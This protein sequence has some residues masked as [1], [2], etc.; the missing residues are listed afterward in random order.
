MLRFR[1]SI[2]FI[3]T[4]LFL[5]NGLGFLSATPEVR[6]KDIGYIEGIRENQLVGIGLI[7]GLAGK[8]DSSSSEILKRSISNILNN[9][10]FKI[11]PSE[12]KSKNSAV[13]MLTAE[14]PAF[15]HPGD[16]IDVEVS[17][18]ADARS[19]EGGILLQTPLKA[20]NGKI[21]GVAQGKL[22]VDK[23]QKTVGRIHNGAIIEEK[24]ETQ[25]FNNGL[26]S[27]VLRNPD[28]ITAHAVA[29]AI[30]K[31]YPDLKVESRDASYIEVTVPESQRNNLVPFIAS[32]ESVSVKPDSSGKVVIDSDSGVIIMG[33]NVRIGKVAVSYK[34]AKITVGY[35]R[36][37]ENDKSFVM[38][39]TTTVN[40]FV[41]TLKTIGLKTDAVIAI[42]KAI[43]RAGALY[44][45]LIV[46]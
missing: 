28:F 20:A 2:W 21:Y 38:K 3:M 46:M 40:D 45:E 32:L 42:L 7:T 14:I 13:V 23:T 12:I 15:V 17:S 39:E 30:R 44:G 16:R 27:I 5:I 9:F 26:V 1:K 4:G 35:T 41:D 18:I 43:D 37:N 25:F 6:I 29:E 10:G 8:G 11:T 31:K 22:A 19:L 34:T 33:E 36:N 24:L